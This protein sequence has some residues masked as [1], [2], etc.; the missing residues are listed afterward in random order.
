MTW[1]FLIE[2]TRIQ[3]WVT[4]RH[5]VTVILL[6]LDSYGSRAAWPGTGAGPVDLPVRARARVFQP[7]AGG[8]S[9]RP[10]TRPRTA[11]RHAKRARASMIVRR[12]AVS[13]L[14]VVSPAHCKRGGSSTLCCP[15]APPGRSR[16]RCCF[17]YRQRVASSTLTSAAS[18]STAHSRRPL[19]ASARMSWPIS[20]GLHACCC[21]RRE[22]GEP[23][24][25]A[26]HA[27]R[28]ALISPLPQGSSS[29]SR[30]RCAAS[31]LCS[32]NPVPSDIATAST[33]L[34]NLT[35]F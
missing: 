18:V 3:Y 13:P 19:P 30:R 28:Y 24:R 34:L 29:T 5:C 33:V 32:L 2:L 8:R 4:C 25:A 1:N 20:G 7:A 23:A 31:V 15:T 17:R 22:R 12:S 35:N 6:R 14:A 21:T 27:H 16:R 9:L 26:P 10:A 11:A